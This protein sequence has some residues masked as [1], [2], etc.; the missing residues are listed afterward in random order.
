VDGWT[1]S[2]NARVP[3]GNAMRPGPARVHSRHTL[4]TTPQNN[5]NVTRPRRVESKHA[6]GQECVTQTR[7]PPLTA[8]TGGECPSLPIAAQRSGVT[9]S[10]G[11]LLPEAV[12]VRSSTPMADGGVLVFQRCTQSTPLTQD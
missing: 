7:C 8:N 12:S 6:G 4:N 5:S 3:T 2:I 11:Q 1:G 10:N 9:G